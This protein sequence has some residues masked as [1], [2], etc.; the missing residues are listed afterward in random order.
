MFKVKK[1]F[2]NFLRR[3]W[4]Q[5][6]IQKNKINIKFFFFLRNFKKNTKKK[7]TENQQ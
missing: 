6:Q 2:L 3:L 7:M 5:L 1:E 4:R